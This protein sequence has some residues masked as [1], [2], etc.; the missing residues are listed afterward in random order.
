MCLI[1]AIEGLRRELLNHAMESAGEVVVGVLDIV[2]ELSGNNTSAIACC[3]YC[4]Y[5][6]GGAV[7]AHVIIHFIYRVQVSVKEA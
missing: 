3:F 2:P 4:V 7:F 5:P 6:Q 1:N